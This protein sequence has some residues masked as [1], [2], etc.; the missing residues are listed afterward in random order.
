LSNNVTPE[1]MARA[2]MLYRT[3]A[4]EIRKSMLGFFREVG[5]RGFPEIIL[6]LVDEEKAIR[7]LALGYMSRFSLR[8]IPFLNHR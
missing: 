6:G 4:T 3:G 1:V 2:R 5:W 7:D 8:L